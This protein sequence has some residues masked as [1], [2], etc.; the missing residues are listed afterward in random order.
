MPRPTS[1][2]SE[3]G[4]LLSESTADEVENANNGFARPTEHQF[5][6]PLTMS[7][8]T[9][10]T[11]SNIHE[12]RRN[13]QPTVNLDTPQRRPRRSSSS[14]SYNPPVGQEDHDMDSSGDERIED[15]ADGVL[16]SASGSH[17][18]IHSL[19]NGFEYL[20]NPTV[21]RPLE[22][23][24]HEP[25]QAN[26]NNN[27]NL[28]VQTRRIR[29]QELERFS[30]RQQPDRQAGLISSE[31]QEIGEA[32]DGDAA[33]AVHEAVSIVPE[34]FYESLTDYEFPDYCFLCEYTCIRH[35]AVQSYHVQNLLQ[36]I[37]ENMHM[38]SADVWTYHSQQ[39]YNIQIRKHT[40]L[41][42]PWMRKQIFDHFD[43][44]APTEV[45][46]KETSLQ[47]F[48]AILRSLRDNGIFQRNTE[49]SKVTV[50]A[51]CVHLFL[52]V[53]KQ[54][55]MTLSSLQSIRKTALL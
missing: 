10:S 48:N 4:S 41:K 5:N 14:E 36:Y 37:N 3:T 55:N 23:I 21:H 30:R 42:L 33:L 1:P 11:R 29:Y 32:H 53:E 13:P 9:A 44:H 38:S 17:N 24:I 20:L 31:V 15:N 22:E 52:K 50:D 51:K 8:A 40:E 12:H 27:D 16:E 2:T 25:N 49:N 43:K 28:V 7:I 54:R 45:S 46:M 35:N 34:T 19:Q 39:Y 47:T 26:A 18:S 6:S